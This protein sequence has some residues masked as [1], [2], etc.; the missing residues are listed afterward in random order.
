MM[1]HLKKAETSM[2]YLVVNV[3]KVVFQN[4]AIMLAT[5]LMFLIYSL[6]C[7]TG[8]VVLKLSRVSFFGMNFSYLQ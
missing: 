1:H 7:I 8:Y 6:I 5:L 4:R 3:I 2:Q